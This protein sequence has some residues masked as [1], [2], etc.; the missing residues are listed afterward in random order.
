MVPRWCGK[1]GFYTPPHLVMPI[2]VEPSKPRMCHD[3]RFLN[4]WMKC[5]TV[6]FDPITDLPSFFF[7]QYH[8]Q[9]KL[10]DKSGYDHVKLTE[11]SRTFFGIAWEGYFFVYNTLPFGWSPSACI[12]RTI[13]LAASHFIR[14]NGVPLSQ[15]IDD[16]HIG[17]IRLKPSIQSAWSNVELAEAAVFTASLVLVRCGYFI[18]TQ[19]SV[20][21]RS[22]KILF[23]GLISDSVTQ[24]FLLP[25]EK[26]ESFARLRESIIASQSVSTKTPQRF[27]SKV[28][29]FSL[30]VPAARL[31]ILVP[32][33]V[34]K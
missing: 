31:Y 16:R 23:L 7:E 3:E 30:A 26:K 15:Y 17:Q 4:L 34:S 10:D 28:I 29:S 27:A 18:G 20:L 19:K 13:G 6:K 24:S 25:P 22:Q 5:L 2:T 33:T 21:R 12:Y 14:S 32:T 1:K 9:T 8:Y 11:N